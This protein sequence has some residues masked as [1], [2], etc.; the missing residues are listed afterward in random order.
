MSIPETKGLPLEEVATLVGDQHEVMVFSDDIQT[1]ATAGE[2]VIKD[3]VV[4]EKGGETAGKTEVS[5]RHEFV[6]LS[7]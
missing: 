7:T 6:E 2:L 3:H 4:E 1:G 5:A